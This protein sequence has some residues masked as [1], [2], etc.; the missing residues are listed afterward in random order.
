MRRGWAG[1]ADSAACPRT[2]LLSF[3]L[4]AL[5]QINPTI[6]AIEA[7]AA[8]IARVAA[9]ARDAGADAVVFPELALSGY[10]PRDLLLQEGFVDRCAAAAKRLG[11]SASAGITLIF[12][13]PLPVEGGTANSLLVYR[14][15]VY[16]D[17]CDKRLL[18]TYDVFDE[19]R[20]F[21]KGHRP[22]VI[23]IAGVRT[24]LSICE[25]LWKAEDVGF[26]DRYR[27]LP[28]PVAALVQAGAQLIINPSASPFV[29]GKGPRH[30]EL[31]KGHATRHGIFVAAVNQVGGNDELIFDG[32]ACA[33]DPSGALLAAGPGFED[34]LTMVEIPAAR[35]APP[36]RGSFS[37][38]GLADPLLQAPREQLLFRALVLGVRDY[39]RKTGF[40][41]ALLGLSGGIDSAVVAAIAAAAIGPRN[42]LGLLMPGPYS[43]E[44]S[45][46]DARDL[47]ARLRMPT[48]TV[49]I[50]PA[51]EG[52]RTITDAAF[53]ELGA[54]RLGQS[55]PDLA[56][57][58]AQSRLRGL[59]NMT[60]SNRT[61]ALVLTTG[62]KSELSVGYCTLYGDMNGGLAVISDL[63]KSMVY[64]LARWMNANA[65]ACGFERAP[66]PENCIAKPPSAE[67]APNQKD[68]DS[69]PPYDVLD[70]IVERYVERHQSPERIIRET[71][72]DEATVRRVVRLTDISE[73]KRKQLT[74]GL[75]VTSVAFGEG[76]RMP[77]ARG[78]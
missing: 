69:L 39:C 3:V 5:A 76:R 55:L 15:G 48:V 52:L 32:H 13:C 14:D 40:K 71:G 63:T 66:I 10:P 30:R 49:P 6:G 16:L 36:P 54:K 46:T 37:A 65:A 75:K 68:Q 17:F 31:L 11:E 61:G 47:A 60:V 59:I 8:L 9:Q 56:E 53:D 20:Y 23:D 24:G 35:W 64:A 78:W 50:G 2:H 72:I 51:L 4:L 34:A 77:I 12:G 28:D 58:N 19:D 67:L 38:S 22:V 74:V 43:T 29:L 73:Y 70:E 7:N 18:P 21:V 33:F 27:N 42:V 25:D 1:G 57:E 45:L 62:N 26:S 41:T 44:H